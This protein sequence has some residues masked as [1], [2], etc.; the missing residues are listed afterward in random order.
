MESQPFW[1]NTVAFTMIWGSRDANTVA[2]PM[3]WASRD[4]NTVIFIMIWTSRDADTVVFYNDLNLQGCKYRSFYYD[5]SL[6]GCKYHSLY[7]DLSLEGS[8]NWL[9]LHTT[10]IPEGYQKGDRIML[11]ESRNRIALL[12]AHRKNAGREQQMS[13]SRQGLNADSHMHF[14]GLTL[15]YI[16]LH[17]LM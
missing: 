17:G 4:A 9:Y 5:L 15:I 3:I 8:I 16:D 12:P 7:Y 1:R 6:Q 14:Y 2:F 11:R 13:A 10:M